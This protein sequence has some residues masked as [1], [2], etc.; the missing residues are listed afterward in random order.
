MKTINLILCQLALLCASGGQLQASAN[1][2]TQQENQTTIVEERLQIPLEAHRKL[3]IRG[4]IETVDLRMMP[5]HPLSLEL[6]PEDRA[7]LDMTV[8]EGELFIT[9]RPE[10]FKKPRFRFF[11]R[12]NS[13]KNKLGSMVLY[14]DSLTG[15]KAAGKVHINCRDT[16]RTESLVVRAE[17]QSSVTVLM[18]V[19]GQTGLY[20]SGQSHLKGA[21]RSR[22][23]IMQASGQSDIEAQDMT[24]EHATVAASGQSNIAL[25]AS[26]SLQA[27]ASGQSDIRAQD[28]TC[29]HA[30][31]TACGQS[32]IALRVSHSLQAEA[33]GESD[34]VYWGNPAK[35]STRCNGA[36]SIQGKED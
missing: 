1:N 13:S 18:D 8:K 36:S 10:K 32:D 5:G 15:I 22:T 7:E 23:C 17:G 3:T 30:T 14:A 35:C 4:N 25:R 20:A 34:I 31:V 21:G 26:H 33:S 24:C 2:A 9:Q 19:N 29:Q 28:M 12:D 27:E 6:K 16:L 11:Y